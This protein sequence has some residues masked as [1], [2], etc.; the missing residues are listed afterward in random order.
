MARAS[1]VAEPVR[2]SRDRILRA[3]IELADAE[4]IEGLSM[5]RLAEELDAAPMALYRH[6]ASKDDLLDGM[7][8]LVFAELDVPT[9]SGWRAAMRER[10]IGMRRALLRHPWA[11]GKMEGGTPGPASFRHHN[12]TM[13]CL[14]AQAGLPF[15]MAVHA[16]SAMDSYIYGFALQETTLPFRDADEAVAEAERRQSAAESVMTPEAF[17]KEYPFL[18]EIAQQLAE[19]RYDYDAEFAF[20][21]DLVLDGIERL[22]ERETGTT[23]RRRRR[24]VSP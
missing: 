21:L 15:P 3:A 19:S 18:F 9:G 4:G 14:R 20:G 17:A 5:R 24:A 23:T 22:V 1:K 10:A 13:G 7:I 6:V 16:Y 12:A 2:L 11:V 8:D